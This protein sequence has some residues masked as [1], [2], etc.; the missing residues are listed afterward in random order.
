MSN[1]LSLAIGSILG[2]VLSYFATEISAKRRHNE[3]K[4]KNKKNTTNDII[5]SCLKFL[6]ILKDGVNDIAT[7]KKT[8]LLLKS[9]FP[10]KAGEMEKA[11]YQ[12]AYD[13]AEGGIFHELMF[14]TYQLKRIEDSGLW[15]EFEAIGNAYESMINILIHDND[16]KK[17]EEAEVIYNNK[18]KGFVEKCLCMTKV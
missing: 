6:F 11:I 16:F 8:Y 10:E 15:K 13:K 9:K 12:A 17:Y 3:D 2:A 7:K 4:E 1:Y 5:G 18:L 14:I